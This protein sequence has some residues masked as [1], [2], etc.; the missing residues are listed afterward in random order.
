MEKT[1]KQKNPLWRYA[2]KNWWRYLIVAVTMGISIVLDIWFPIITMSIVDDVIVDGNMEMLKYNLICILIVGFGRAASQYIKEFTCDVTGSRVASEARKNLFNH[3]QTLSKTYFD[4]NNTG[5]LMARVKDDVD[6]LWDV[7]GFVGMLAVEAVAYTI[8]VIICMVRIDWRLSLIPIA[9]LPVMGV[10]AI[11]LERRLDKVYDSISEQN[12][13]LN[14]VV[15]ENL[16]GV[17]TVK[18]FARESYEM[19][20]FRK[21]NKKYYDLNVEQATIMANFEPKMSFMPKVMQLLVLLIG[22]AFVVDGRISLGVLIA[23]IQYAN[24]IVWP[25][26]N[27][28]WLTNA[29]AAAAASNKKINQILAEK[30]EIEDKEDAQVLE[31]PKGS[32][33]FDKVTFQIHGN[34]IL[35]NVSFQLESGRTLGIMGMTGAGKSTIVNLINR[36]YDVSEGSI[37]IDGRDI[38]NLTLESVRGCTSVVTQDVFLFSDTIRENIKLGRRGTMQD[39]AVK[40]A[41]AAAHAAEFVDK[42]KEG[43]DT[44]I[45]ERG[46]GLSGGQKQRLSIARA[47][48][49][50]AKILILDDS[51]SAL[52]METEY[53]IQQTLA[54]KKEISK[55]I[56]AHRISSVRNADEIIVLDHG[57]IAERGTHEE[58]LKKKGF[59]YATYEAQYGDYHNAMPGRKEE[60]CPLIP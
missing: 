17:R 24:N 20:K 31:Q 53:E 33:T 38:R 7:F 29:V 3:I 45:G 52:D 43:Y 18:A 59:Y 6:R 13:V 23:F 54:A 14:M 10:M 39:T 56:I 16:S 11:R 22:G 34:R 21:N 1:V 8:G 55:I 44:V 60:S 19:D 15:Q 42:L 48:A 30:P 2:G 46:V 40:G 9:V 5:E 25:M 35:E 28:G 50:D 4:R 12:A 36:F 41:L 47:L 57:K 27:L 58:L 51:T 32:L 26:E 37:C 49:K